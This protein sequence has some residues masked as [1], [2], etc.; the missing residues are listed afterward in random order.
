MKT[1]AAHAAL[2]LLIELSDQ[3]NQLVLDYNGLRGQLAEIKAE[4]AE[5][6]L[7]RDGVQSAMQKN[8]RPDL[9]EFATWVDDL[10]E[11]ARS[12]VIEQVYLA[13]RAYSWWA[14]QEFPIYSR[15]GLKSA[16]T[17]TAGILKAAQ[18][19]L[20]NQFRIAVESRATPPNP[21]PTVEARKVNP[22]ARG[23]VVTLDA[24][25]FRRA[26]EDLRS[27]YATTV[28]LPATLPYKTSVPLRPPGESGSMKEFA[29]LAE[30]MIRKVRVYLRGATASDGLF[31][32][33]ITHGGVNHVVRKDGIEFVFTSVPVHL[34]F[35]YK[36]KG[37]ATEITFDSDI[38]D[39]VDQGTYAPL[40]PFGWW[41]ISVDRIS[42]PSV[43]LKG[44][45]AV[46]IE[47]HGGAYGFPD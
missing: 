41:R 20:L 28:E 25:N 47:F 46:E 32:I 12:S 43:D 13:S 40:S 9:P 45:K 19:E 4:I 35:K 24:D 37:D 21:F 3:R 42:H 39:Q 8:S 29:M 23:V 33:N 31:A 15:L 16:S 2:D 6:K 34:T 17:V 14:L 44:L 30:V 5:A 27:N 11:K 22:A 18:G 7:Q 36:Q 38:T 1:D 10:Y 26:F